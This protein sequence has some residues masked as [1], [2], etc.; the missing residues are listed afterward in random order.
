MKQL[1]KI[2]LNSSFFLFLLALNLYCMAG[3]AAQS[4]L[5]LDTGY[6]YDRVDE[7]HEFVAPG[8]FISLEIN[9]HN[10]QIYLLGARGL[11]HDPSLCSQFIV[12][13]AAHYGWIGAG[14]FTFESA[15]RGDAGGYT[16]DA[17]G[18]LGYS[19]CACNCFE[20]VPLVGFSY[21]KH[22][23]K[24]RKIFSS[25]SNTFFN[26]IDLDYSW[27]G[28]WAG[29]DIYFANYSYCL[30]L[31][32]D[33][34]Y[35]FHYGWASFR[36]KDSD[37]FAQKFH[38]PDMKGHVFHLGT[39]YHFC[40]SWLA[41]IRFQYTFW[42]NAHKRRSTQNVPSTL[43]GRAVELRWQSFEAMANIGFCF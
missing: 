26:D 32:F 22:H 31:D 43:V 36:R 13:G 35:E 40:G 42:N 4:Y 28:P 21:D 14:D 37:G 6:R 1:I 30:P 15:R 18:G 33:V 12:K 34:G 9:N 24:N 25:I 11:W 10:T 23:F 20:F 29:F 5:L 17:I 38:M 2:S 16:V 3:Y 8:Q 39:L 41:G 27:Y 19:L 7:D